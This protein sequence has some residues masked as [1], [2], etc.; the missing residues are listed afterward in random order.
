VATSYVPRLI[1]LATGQSEEVFANRLRYAQSPG[2]LYQ[3]WDISP[4]GGS[5]VVYHASGTN[6]P[7]ADD[8]LVLYPLDDSENG[9]VLLSS[10]SPLGN[11]P[12]TPCFVDES[13]VYVVGMGSV[14][15]VDPT[16]DATQTPEKVTDIA[17]ADELNGPI[18]WK[19]DCSAF[20]AQG[21]RSGDTNEDAVNTAWLSVE[22]GTLTQISEYGPKNMTLAQ[23]T[24]F[25]GC[26]G[27]GCVTAKSGGTAE[28]MGWLENGSIWFSS[29]RD[30]WR[31]NAN[32]FQGMEQLF[33]Y[34]PAAPAAFADL[35]VYDS[36]PV[37]AVSRDGAYHAIVSGES[38]EVLD[39]QG[40]RLVL[41][42][43]VFNAANSPGFM[44]F[45]K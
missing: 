41:S 38:I 34:D 42:D 6:A 20:V 13:T 4:D 14:W 3:H 39:A 31:D 9:K 25:A 2:H 15:K 19:S 8:R 28:K 32:A 5:I 36:P 37:R 1:D 44:R 43:A 7:G 26:V 30:V 23:Q 10:A 11:F 35:T 29:N 22:T 18:Y 33:G 45:I 16:L 12:T 17:P 40:T 27:T 24:N 21:F